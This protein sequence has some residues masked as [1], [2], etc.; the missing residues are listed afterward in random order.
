[1]TV[2]ET[3]CV[4]SR[5][6]KANFDGRPARQPPRQF[7]ETDMLF[8]PAHCSYRCKITRYGL[9]LQGE[10]YVFFIQAAAY[11]L[12]M[13]HLKP[14]INWALQRQTGQRVRAERLRLRYRQPEFAA[15]LGLTKNQ[16]AFIETG[17]TAVR[18]GFA[19]RLHKRFGTDLAWLADLP[20]LPKMPASCWPNPE[21]PDDG[22]WPEMLFNEAAILIYARGFGHLESTIKAFPDERVW[23]R[24]Q[25]QEVM[26]HLL[27]DLLSR[28]PNHR[29]TDFWKSW[30]EWHAKTAFEFAILPGDPAQSV[31]AEVRALE[32]RLCMQPPEEY[33][34]K[35]LTNE[36]NAVKTLPVQPMIPTLLERLRRATAS[37]G[38]KTDLAGVLGVPPQRVNGWLSGSNEPGGETTLR[39][40][41]WV[42]AEEAKQKSSGSVLAP[43]EPKARPHESYEK[44]PKSDPP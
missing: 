3:F 26:L 6:A 11:N 23:A 19:H 9:G 14:P 36:R 2:G 29:L 10:F 18:Y 7:P 17:K 5:P 4:R 1:M 15:L 21:S 39:L 40:L 20:S 22:I 31:R 30:E 37:R 12:R 25:A 32:D 35:W 38:R 41:A 13:P 34:T 8:E 42:T 33:G 44:K 28:I 27:G 16:L 43:P 24:S